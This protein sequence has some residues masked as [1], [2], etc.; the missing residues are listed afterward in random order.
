VFADGENRHETQH[1]VKNG[2]FG[3]FLSRNVSAS[4]ITKKNLHRPK[5]CIPSVCPKNPPFRPFHEP[6]RRTT[7][8]KISL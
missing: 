1:V 8:V 6:I 3:Y 5:P 4:K 7:P 2:V